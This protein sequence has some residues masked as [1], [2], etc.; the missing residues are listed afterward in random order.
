MVTPPGT[1]NPA[2]FERPYAP[3]WLHVLVDRIDR[4]PGPTWIAYLAILVV[5]ILAM[6]VA[7]WSRGASPV[8]SLDV[9]STYWGFL[10][11]ALIWVAAYFERMAARAFDA[12]RPALTTSEAASER[13]R[14]TLI[15]VPAAPSIVLNVLGGILTAATFVFD[16]ASYG[17][18]GLTG[19]PLAI[20]FVVQWINTA[21]L[22]Q[23]L[24]RLIRQMRLVRQTLEESVVVDLFRPGPLNAFALLTSRPG[25]VLTLLVASSLVLVPLPT[26]L[27]AFLVG[28]APYLIVPPIIAVITFLV[29][30]TGAHEQL[31]AQKGRLQGETDERLRGILTDL[32]RDVD[33][34]D[35][36][37]ADQLNKTL[38]SLLVQRDLLAKLPTWPWSTATLRSFVTAILL[39][40]ALFLAQQGFSRLF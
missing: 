37:R 3:S 12:F 35:L 23:L 39:P 25:A 40:M 4:L 24:Y 34:R 6:H 5:A 19:P 20:L 26:E 32:N 9:L 13:L 7:P 31:V 29:P 17:G 2:A 11:A 1:A 27:D 30:L 18:E 22:F 15:V 36:G 10:T 38:A 8:G 14:Y 16:P 28:W 33:A 21:I